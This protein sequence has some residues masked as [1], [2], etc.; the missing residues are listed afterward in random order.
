LDGWA[1]LD[2]LEGMAADGKGR[3][4]RPLHIRSVTIHANPLAG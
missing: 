1:V 3:V 4:A 2:A